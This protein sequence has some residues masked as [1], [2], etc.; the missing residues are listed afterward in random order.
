MVYST[1][2]TKKFANLQDKKGFFSGNLQGALF[3]TPHSISL[4][5]FA[6]IRPTG[7]GG[8]IF[9]FPCPI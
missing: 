2:M 9:F 3:A 8:V 4:E 7:G 5:K 1:K 6:S